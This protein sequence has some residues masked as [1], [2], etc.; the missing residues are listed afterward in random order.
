MIV[1]QALKDATAELAATVGV[2]GEPQLLRLR[3]GGQN[4]LFRVDIGDKSLLLKRYFPGVGERRERLRREFSFSRYAWSVGVREIPEAIA[5]DYTRHMAFFSFVDAVFPSPSEILPTYLPEAMRLVAKINGD[6]RG[7]TAQALAPAFGWVASP[8]EHAP[9]LKGRLQ[10]LRERADGLGVDPAVAALL[11][12]QLLPVSVRVLQT[13]RDLPPLKDTERVLSPSA[14]ALQHVLLTGGGNVLFHDFEHAGWDDPARLV[15][16]VVTLP[17]AGVATHLF[18]EL[19][20]SMRALLGLPESFV[21][22]A[23]TMVPLFRLYTCCQLL[24]EILPAQ[25]RQD[26][27]SRWF[28]PTLG[29]PWRL[30]QQMMAMLHAHDLR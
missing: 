15:A 29:T 6:R 23:A 28:A 27:R 5:A 12:Q 7:L 25:H 24:D 21:G 22:R 19:A 14:S 2:Y 18:S 4:R 16:E 8:A 17:Q 13:L 26:G 11:E 3:S 30:V 20:N 10:Q 1:D 9:I